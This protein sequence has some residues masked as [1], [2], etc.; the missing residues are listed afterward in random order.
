[1]RSISVVPV[2]PT[3]PVTAT[4]APVMRARA[5]APMRRS[6]ASGSSGT[7]RSGAGALRRA[8][9]LDNRER[10]AGLQRRVDEAMPVAVLAADRDEGLARP[11]AC[12]CRSRRR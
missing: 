1:M 7:T 3:E 6:A 10:R 11:D 8:S 5:A 4:T 2:L 9:L 12:G